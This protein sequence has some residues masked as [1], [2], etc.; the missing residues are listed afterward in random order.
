MALKDIVQHKRMPGLS[1]VEWEESKTA[2]DAIQQ[3]IESNKVEMVD[4]KFTDLLGTWQHLSLTPREMGAAAFR[5]GIGFDGSSIRGFQGIERSDMVLIPDA[6]TALIDPFMTR[7]TLHLIA[8]IYDP[9]TRDRYGKDPRAVAERAESHLRDSGIADLSCWGPEC[10]FFVFDSISYDSE[11]DQAFYRVDSVEAAWNTG[12]DDKESESNNPNL[13]YKTEHK[14]GYFPVPPRDTLQDIRTEMV[15]TM[16]SLGIDTEV[17]HHE[18]ATA[19]QCEID[20]RYDSLRAMADKVLWYKYIVRNVARQAG[21]TATFMPKPIFEDNGSGMHVHQ[22]L[23]KDEA[24]LFYDPEGYAGSS[25]MARHYIGGLIKH[26]PALMAFCAPTTN[27]YKRLVPGYEAPTTLVYSARNRSAAIRIPMYSQS[28]KSKRLEFRSPDPTANPYLAFS[29]LLMAGLDGIRN[30][31]DPG[32]PVDDV[33]L[34]EIDLAEAGYP[35]LPNSLA[36]ALDALERDHAFLLEG[37]VFTED[38][39]QTWIGYKRNAEVDP[40][41]MRPHPYEFQL[42]FDV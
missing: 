34:F 39:I 29:A 22:S 28:P 1:S 6:S 30:Q 37:G 15:L 24:P 19:G 10:E 5:E 32:D 38:L 11:R 17:H 3:F 2:V 41:R 7:R 42:Y 31:I 4:I 23:W 33:D 40:M 14:E 9:V 25:E 16:E 12:V 18:V 13:G 21:K 35:Q 36:G 26:G 20:L 8:D 27:S